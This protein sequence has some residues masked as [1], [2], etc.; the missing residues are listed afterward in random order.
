MNS[1]RQQ[2]WQNPKHTQVKPFPSMSVAERPPIQ[3]YSEFAKPGEV[4]QNILWLY[5]LK[6]KNPIG[7]STMH[8]FVPETALQILHAAAPE[9]Q[10][11]QCSAAELLPFLPCTPSRNSL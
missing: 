5:V 6:K 1:L 11:L 9:V 10:S 8:L 4:S 7:D 3:R 2:V